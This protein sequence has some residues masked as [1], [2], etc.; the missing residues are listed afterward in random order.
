M[1]N[2][3]FKSTD[4]QVFRLELVCFNFAVFLKK[5]SFSFKSNKR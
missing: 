5:L 2:V 4:Y 3:K 1:N